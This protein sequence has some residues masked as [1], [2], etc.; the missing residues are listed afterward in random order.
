MGPDDEVL[1]NLMRRILTES[2]DGWGGYVRAGNGT[3]VID[4]GWSISDAELLVVSCLTGDVKPLRPSCS[5]PNC[6]RGRDGRVIDGVSQAIH[7][8]PACGGVGADL[9]A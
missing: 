7:P 6:F 2:A 4:G 9:T 1:A 3:L 5:D 8:C